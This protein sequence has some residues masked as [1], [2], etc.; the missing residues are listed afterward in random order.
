M[1]R[2]RSYL[3]FQIEC[4]KKDLIQALNL[5]LENKLASCKILNGD[6][7]RILKKNSFNIIS[8]FI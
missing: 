5:T 3:L 2:H 6:F 4:I 7:N 1:A 8:Y